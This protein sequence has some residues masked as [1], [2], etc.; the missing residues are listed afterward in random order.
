MYNGKI[1]IS[2]CSLGLDTEPWKHEGG[3]VGD[4]WENVLNLICGN[5][6]PCT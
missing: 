6:A 2:D 1:Q 5:T 4:M 3:D